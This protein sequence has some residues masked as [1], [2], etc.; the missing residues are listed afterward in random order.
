MKN[1]QTFTGKGCQI[2]ARVNTKRHSISIFTCRIK[3]L[4]DAAKIPDV[5][6]TSIKTVSL[7]STFCWEIKLNDTSRKEQHSAGK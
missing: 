2:P 3:S 1:V 7:Q 4:K 6:S 5:L